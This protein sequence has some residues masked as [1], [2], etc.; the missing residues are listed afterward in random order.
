MKN[1]AYSY[2][3]VSTEI[4]ASSGDGM[5]R[6]RD[7]ALKFLKNYPDYILHDEI[8]DAGV[9]AY[10]G[11]N[12][13]ADAGL[14]KFIAAVESGKIEHDSLLILE[15]ADRLS[16][17][18]IRK[19]QT[20][21]QLLFDYKINI[22]LVKFNLILRHDDENDISGA[23]LVAAALYLGRLESEQKSKRIKEV[24]DIQR[25]SAAKGGKKLALA[26]RPW[27]T[28]S[29][30]RM[31]FLVNSDKVAIVKRIFDMKISGLGIMKIVDAFNTEGVS[32][33]G[34]AKSNWNTTL[35]TN[36]IKSR[37]VLGEY[38]PRTVQ[39]IDG[40][41]KRVLTGEP[42]KDY[43]PRI[44]P[45]DVFIKAN[46]TFKSTVVG[47]TGTYQHLFRGFMKCACCGYSLSYKNSG[48]SK[49]TGVKYPDRLYCNGEKSRSTDCKIGHIHYKPIEDIVLGVLKFLDFKQIFTPSDNT[50]QISLLNAQKIECEHAISNYTVAIGTVKGN[51]L[52]L[53]LQKLGDCQSDLTE[54]NAKIS[55]LMHS[56]VN[57]D[58]TILDLDLS[59]DSNRRQL[60]QYI[61]KFVDYVS[62]D[63]WEMSIK[64]RHQPHALTTEYHRK[65][66]LPESDLKELAGCYQNFFNTTKEEFNAMDNLEGVITEDCTDWEQHVEMED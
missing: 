23:M 66:G 63:G 36:T 15:N 5:Q 45:D 55:D 65:K 58:K 12:L 21:I 37:T 19:G 3:R 42:I 54:V 50:N 17:Q 1:K 35:V 43:Y 29:D 61:S 40:K 16:R 2:H 34:F 49:Y 28:L 25:R 31:S 51:A 6:Q 41:E 62:S 53:L 56:T 13:L 57:I 46:A 9:S 30:D 32:T 64:F 11:H 22:G 44:I 7:N 14:G 33:I 24:F 60:N 59:I 10:K 47:R 26:K 18:G 20:I 8:N 27:L 4:Q 38:H 52:P 48:K 39:V